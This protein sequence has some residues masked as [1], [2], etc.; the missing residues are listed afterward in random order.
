[1][2]CPAFLRDE[3]KWLAGR[4]GAARDWEVLEGS[5]LDGWKNRMPA[6]IDIGA[7]R[8]AA[9]DSAAA[10]RILAAEAVQSVR[11]TRLQLQF[12]EWMMNK[13]WRALAPAGGVPDISLPLEKFARQVLRH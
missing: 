6:D 7:L 10:N 13:G 4:L 5:T 12:A 1:I 8:K 3:W 2:E 11:H 9:M